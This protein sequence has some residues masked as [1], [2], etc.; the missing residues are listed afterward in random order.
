MTLACIIMLGCMIYLVE[1]FYGICEKKYYSFIILV[2][3]YFL[4]MYTC[5]S[6][7]VIVILMALTLENKERHEHVLMLYI[8]GNFE[9]YILTY[10]GNTYLL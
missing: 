7:H 5:V 8:S 1:T 4:T 2:N 3:K 10:Y 6:D 9:I